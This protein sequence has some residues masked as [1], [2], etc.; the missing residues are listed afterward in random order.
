MMGLQLVPDT[1]ETRERAR[2]ISRSY[3][4]EV[5]RLRLSRTTRT[6]GTEIQRHRGWRRESSRNI[7]QQV[8]ES[9]PAECSLLHRHEEKIK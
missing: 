9:A 6:H 8:Y 5:L 1:G 7:L 3:F 2:R 4:P